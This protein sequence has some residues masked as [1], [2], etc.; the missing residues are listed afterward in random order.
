MLDAGQL[1]AA[2]MRTVTELLD[3]FTALLGGSGAIDMAAHGLTSAE[4]CSR[5]SEDAWPMVDIAV[6]EGGVD[7]EAD[8]ERC[9]V[10]IG[11]GVPTPTLPAARP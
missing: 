10:P 2:H 7:E 3:C 6:A 1:R 5:L 9:M 4:E 8:C 11:A